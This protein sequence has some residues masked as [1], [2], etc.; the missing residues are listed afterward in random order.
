MAGLQSTRPFRPL[1]TNGATLAV[2]TLSQRVAITGA[3]TE[4]RVHT[5]PG[6][7]DVFLELG[8]SDVAATVA[9]GLIL[10]AGAVE[11]FRVPINITYV[12]AITEAG[13]AT[14]YVHGGEGA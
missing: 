10:P 4:I 9:T 14:L 12:A 5:K 8:G 7:A 11:Y 6:D 2:G 1:A 13:S 3:P